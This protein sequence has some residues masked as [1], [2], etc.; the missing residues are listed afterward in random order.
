MNVINQDFSQPHVAVPSINAR[1][2]IQ[3]FGKI[4]DKLIPRG[5]FYKL[6]DFGFLGATN[7]FLWNLICAGGWYGP[8]IYS[9]T[10]GVFINTFFYKNKFLFPFTDIGKQFF[11]TDRVR[12]LASGGTFRIRRT[13][14]FTTV[15]LPFKVCKFHGVL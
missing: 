10:K 2:S 7:L 11:G 13:Q 15:T 1:I 9:F 5:K 6:K 4:F 14:E 3:T 8:S 12:M